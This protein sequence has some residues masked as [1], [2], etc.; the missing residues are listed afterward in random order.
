MYNTH[1]LRRDAAQL[2]IDLHDLARRVDLLLPD[3]TGISREIRSAADRISP[4]V[5][6]INSLTL[7]NYH[8]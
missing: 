5:Q 7:E 8:D 2:E 3:Q 4:L 1:Q 6:Q